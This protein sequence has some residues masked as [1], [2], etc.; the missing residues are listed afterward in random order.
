MGVPYK[1]LTHLCAPDLLALDLHHLSLIGTYILPKGSNWTEWTDVDPE[2]KLQEAVTIL[3][4]L[5]E[6]PL[7]VNGDTN[8][9]TGERIPVGAML[10]RSSSDNVVNSRGRWM[11]RL[12]SD[13]GM[14]ILNGTTKESAK[15][16]AFTSFQ[17]LGSSVIDYCFVSPGLVPRIKD[18]DLRIVKSPIWSD[19]AQ[20]HVAVIKPEARME[21]PTVN[22]IP[23]PSPVLFGDATPL[24][25]LLKATL[26]AAVS[27]KEATAQ[28]YGPV[29]EQSNPLP[30]YIGTSSSK[31][32]SSF[33][34][35][36]GVDCKW[37]SAYA[38]EN[39]ANDGR[40][41]ILA[42][43]C[44]A[45][46]CPLNRSLTIFMSSQY[47]I[48]AFCYWAGDNET[49]GWSCANGE[50]L[51][52]ATEWISRRRAAIEFRWLSS[53]EQNT[54][55]AAAKKA[56]KT[57]LSSPSSAFRYAYEPHSGKAILTPIGDIQL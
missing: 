57:A 16:G 54:S 40:A 25:L 2:I 7:M 12:C 21:L 3:S 1:I 37:N 42:V 9:R 31:G 14:T 33:A 27:S 24:D 53:K 35:W 38:V 19:H 23:R 48:R 5:P 56:A 51:R 13:T 50:E 39:K 30:I 45:R 49:R 20:I 43:L 15:R 28:L 10:A 18:G 44:A 29:F 46:D 41:A 47:V 4:A 22:S 26:E 55:M 32:R 36:R 11:L 17:P 52:D 34:L 6:K 8:S